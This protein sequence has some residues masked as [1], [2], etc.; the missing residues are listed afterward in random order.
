MIDTPRRKRPHQAAKRKKRK[1]PSSS[2]AQSHTAPSAMH[3]DKQAGELRDRREGE[4]KCCRLPDRSPPKGA[5]RDL[6]RSRNAPCARKLGRASQGPRKFA[7]RQSTT[8]TPACRAHGHALTSGETQ[9]PSRHAR[10]RRRP[11]ESRNDR[12][13]DG[14]AS[15]ALQLPAV[16]TGE[17]DDPR[18]QP[19]RDR[20]GAS[21][22]APS[23]VLPAE[24][25]RTRC[26][27]SPTSSSRTARRRWPRCAAARWR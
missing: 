16:S 11:A 10:H 21:P 23:A 2:L 6:P 22:S 27:S 13:R 4:R 7:D 20:H 19:S 5:P 25:S 15:C 1:T 8:R 18:H 3:E 12:R 24:D 17:E 9:A 14:S 26:A